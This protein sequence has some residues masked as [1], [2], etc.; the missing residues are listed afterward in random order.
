MTQTQE[1]KKNRILAGL[2]KWTVA[3]LKEAAA[4][5]GHLPAAEAVIAYQKFVTEGGVK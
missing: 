5:F 2:R 3:D 1:D 4:L